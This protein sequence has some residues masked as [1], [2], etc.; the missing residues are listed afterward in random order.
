MIKIENKIIL[1]L[2]SLLMIG[3][4][5]DSTGLGDPTMGYETQIGS[6]APSN[7]DS[8]KKDLG[9]DS[10]TTLTT[11]DLTTSTTGEV[12][13][14]ESLNTSTGIETSISTGNENSTG[15]ILQECGNLIIEEFE[16]CDDGPEGS[17]SCDPDCTKVICGDALV[18]PH[19][20]ECDD[21]NTEDD[22]E[23][24]NSCIL[25][26]GVFIS[27]KT[28]NG[29][30]I[31]GV[32]EADLQC[33]VLAEGSGISGKYKSW[34]SYTTKYKELQ[35]ES[36]F[37][38]QSYTGWYRLIDGTPIA[39][40]WED[41]VQNGPLEP[42]LVTNENNIV[43]DTGNVYVWTGTTNDGKWTLGQTDCN[44]WGTIQGEEL[45]GKIG[46]AALV[47]QWSDDKINNVIM[48]NSDARLY[49]FE[50]DPNTI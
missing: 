2:S 25:P 34:I 22:D 23:C 26:R 20:E 47:D 21:G 46:N 27:E 17:I 19:I 24:S 13:T 37:D 41:L 6:S 14:T 28:Y 16:E 29:E 45:W 35:V 12:T 39:N 18:N 7:T 32:F 1:I 48:C 10:S 4:T 9:Q 3:C 11:G 40:G 31:K 44:G 42:I 8:F 49:C 36:R 50:V 30:D 43:E 5:F 15:V 33:N 38:S